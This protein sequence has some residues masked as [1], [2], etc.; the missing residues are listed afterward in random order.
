MLVLRNPF[1]KP[2]TLMDVTSCNRTAFK[3]IVSMTINVILDFNISNSFS[4]DTN[5]ERRHQLGHLQ[6]L[7]KKII[8]AR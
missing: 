7:S 2:S 5:M 4:A 8:K 6:I 3:N 1:E